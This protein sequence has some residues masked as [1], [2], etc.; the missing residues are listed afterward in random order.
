MMIFPTEHSLL[1]QPQVASKQKTQSYTNNG[2]G[3]LRIAD[4][5]NTI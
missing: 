3:F 5:L 2:S 4:V 1:N